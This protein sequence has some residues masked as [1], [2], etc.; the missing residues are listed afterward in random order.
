MSTWLARAVREWPWGIAIVAIL[1]LFFIP[2]LV[3]FGA[4]VSDAQRQEIEALHH[5]VE[6]G[7]ASAAEA[8][9]VSFLSSNPRSPLRV[10]ASLLL[11][12]ATLARGRAGIYPGAKELS[13]AWSILMKAPHTPEYSQLRREVASQLEEYG[14]AREAV[15][16]FATLYSEDRSPEL[17]LDLARALVHRAAADPEFRVALLDEASTRVSDALRLLP[18][19]RRVPALRVKARVLREA[20]RDEDLAVQLTTELAETKGRADRGLIELERGRTFARLGRNMEALASLDEAEH[21]IQD[22]LLRGMA[23]VHQAELFLRAENLEGVELSKRIEASDSPASPFARLVLGTWLLKS[24]PAA[25]LEE[26]RRGASAIRRPRTI[27]DAGF[28]P[29]WTRSSLRAATDRESDPGRLLAAAAVYGELLRLWPLSVRLGFEEAAVLLRAGRFE[30]AGKRFLATG[31]SER[32]EAEDRERAVRAAADAFG[33][34][35]LYRRAAALYREYYDLRPAANTA[36]LF[37]RAASL[38]QAGDPVGAMAGF[39]EYV[40]RAG[41]SASLAGTALL[42]KAAVQAASGSW[43]AA[44]LTYDRVLK[45]HDV[46]TSPEKDDWA[47]ALL[48]RARCLLELARPAE[49]RKALEEYLERYAEGPVPTP[50]SVEAAWLL[51]RAAIDERRWKTGLERLRTLDALQARLSEAD[52]APYQ[53]HV[54][55]AG[56]VE[57]DLQFQ[58]GDYAAAYLAYGEAVRRSAA[59]DG[60]LR[61]LI[62]RART[63]A[64]LDR[65]QEARRDYGSAQAIFEELRGKGSEGPAREYWNIALQ[66]L[67]GELR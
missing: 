16:R 41:P 7:D 29:A 54:V 32:A 67:A 49:A 40:S 48:G 35:G 42:E 18:A 38:K 63:L 27:D 2:K 1:S 20:R 17:A 64:R 19:E 39:E 33:E 45:A 50:A 57:G 62:G 51:V 31:A 15:E 21:Q 26:L 30:D 61:G 23:Q 3:R 58:L 14:L 52:R 22:P 9:L 36:G 65:I 13:R 34:G 12:R 43:D 46:T 28:D 24:Q 37:H 59:S 6:T 60:R 11:A 4:F 47:L 53:D 8:R 5:Q 66:A 56:F 25:G 10:E 55:E 44:L